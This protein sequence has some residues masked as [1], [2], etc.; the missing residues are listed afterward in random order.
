M[1]SKSK[2]K[3]NY[4]SNASN[5]RRTRSRG[6]NKSK[7]KSRRSP[8]TQGV[9]R[10]ESGNNIHRVVEVENPRETKF[11]ERKFSKSLGDETYITL[12]NDEQIE[13]LRAAGKLVRI[14]FNIDKNDKQYNNGEEKDNN[15]VQDVLS[16]VEK[17]ELGMLRNSKKKDIFSRLKRGISRLTRRHKNPK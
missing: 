8:K 5:K 7:S 2:S 14:I 15:V 17:P 4:V 10:E 11:V 16:P 1:L 13:E 6:G 3:K 9:G 12:V